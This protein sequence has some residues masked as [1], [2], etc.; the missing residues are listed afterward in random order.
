VTSASVSEVRAIAVVGAVQFVCMLDFMMVMP[1]GPDFATS[2]GIPMS[3]LGLIGGSYTAAA[4][5]SG[6]FGATTLDRFDRRRA[7]IWALAGLAAGTFAG[8]LAVGLGSMMAARI[9]AGIFGGPAVSLA[10]AVVSDVV[11]PERRGRA[12]GIVMAGFAVASVLGVPA[13]LE[14][15]RLGSFRTPFF[16]VAAVGAALAT[17]VAVLLPPLR[18]H[19]DGGRPP[20]S[21]GELLRRPLSRRMALTVAVLTAG[22]F[23]L[24]P[25]LAAYWQFN[26]GFPRSQLGFLFLIGGI[27]S[28]FTTTLG[29]RLADR[30]GA[31]TVA[32]GGTALYAAVLYAAFL[33][34]VHFVPVLILSPAYMAT[35]GLRVVP[36]QAVSSRVPAPDERAR[37]MSLMSA[38]QHLFAAVGAVAGARALVVLPDGSLGGMD[39]IAALALALGVLSPIVL[40][41]VERNLPEHVAPG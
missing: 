24:V 21:L 4:A 17:A 41:S 33:S 26:Y 29:G 30:I 32:A 14:L 40:G 35:M 2:L 16:V 39:R 22:N 13:G 6:F 28:L 37:F 9:L 15:S 19:L 34:P 10:L 36:M 3:H 12:M 11:P 23:L 7:L 8:G 25:N 20:S 1:L 18:A 38:V 5:L 31:T 27:I